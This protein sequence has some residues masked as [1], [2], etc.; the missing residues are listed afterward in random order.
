MLRC[1]EWVETGK[2]ENLNEEPSVSKYAQERL[3]VV[4]S[5]GS[6]ETALSVAEDLC[7]GV[8]R[9]NSEKADWG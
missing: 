7:K 9:Y 3:I 8:V 4:S 6:E 2:C 5:G 1:E